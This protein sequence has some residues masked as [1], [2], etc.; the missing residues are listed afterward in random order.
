MLFN[1]SSNIQVLFGEVWW[2]ILLVAA[3]SYMIGNINFALIISKFKKSDVRKLGSGNPGTLNMSRNFGIKIGMVTFVLDLLK[4]GL[5]SFVCWLMFKGQY[6]GGVDLGDFTRFLS[7]LMVVIGHIYPALMDFKGGKGVAATLGVFLFA[8]PIAAAVVF[9]LS[10]ALIA[11]TS[12][13]SMGSFMSVSLL[14]VC[15]MIVFYVKYIHT[16]G[17]GAFLVL[18]YVFIFAMC[19]MVWFAH[20]KNIVR[21]AAGEEHPTSVKKRSVKKDGQS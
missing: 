17:T 9:A 2:Q 4:G 3:L 6:I 14:A 5:P 18:L 11:A 1:I 15:Q 21:I 13:G 16:G 20:R 12:W 19:L 7:G 8:N 10:F